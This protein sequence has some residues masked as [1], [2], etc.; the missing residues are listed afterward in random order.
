MYFKHS[1][2]N[3]LNNKLNQERGNRKDTTQ[4]DEPVISIF[5]NEH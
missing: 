2:H 5:I 4:I 3:E 1:N